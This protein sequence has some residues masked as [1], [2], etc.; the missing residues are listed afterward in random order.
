MRMSYFSNRIFVPP[1]PRLSR[2]RDMYIDRSTKNSELVISTAGSRLRIF[3]CL[4]SG[5]ATRPFAYE[6]L[7]ATRVQ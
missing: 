1:F 7:C 6:N 4:K 5:S 2:I 3:L